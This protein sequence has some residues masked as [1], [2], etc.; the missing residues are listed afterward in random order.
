MTMSAPIFTTPKRQLT[1]LITGCS[2]GFGLS[3][4]RAVLAAGQHRVVATSRNPSRT[5]ELVREVERAGGRWLAL[6]VD[7]PHSD[8]AIADPEQARLGVDVLV[9]NAGFSVFAAVESTTEA[10]VRADGVHEHR[11]PCA[12]SVWSCQGCATCGIGTIINCSSEAALEGVRGMG[13]YAGTKAALDG[14]SPLRPLR[15]VR[16]RR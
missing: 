4:I 5:P 2:S 16:P 14:T 13:P 10:E 8:R 9:N 3:L 15:C 7:D 12:W 6:D 1:F 11:P